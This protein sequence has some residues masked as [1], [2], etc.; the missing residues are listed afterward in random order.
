MTVY[1]DIENPRNLLSDLFDLGQDG[2][3]AVDF[4]ADSAG[5]ESSGFPAA[6]F[7]GEYTAEGRN[8]S[9]AG[10][11][12]GLKGAYACTAEPPCAVDADSAGLMSSPQAWTFTPDVVEGATIDVPDGDHLYFGWWLSEPEDPEG[13]Y[14]FRAFSGGSDSFEPGVKFTRDDAGLLEGKAE[15]RGL[16][17]GRYVTMDFSGGEITGADTGAFTATAELTAKFGGDDIAVNEHFSISGTV[18]DFRDVEDDD[19]LDD[20]S[21]ELNRIDLASGSASFE[22][23]ATEAQLGDSTGTGSWEGAFFGNGR[24]DGKPGSVAGTFEARLTAA[25]I[26][27]GFGA[28]NIAP[29]E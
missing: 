14:A 1:S 23:G 4:S 5:I 12:Y 10:T 9:F 17:A 18:T 26:S 24:S 11:F 27:G 19:P 22:G 21:V 6:G 15:Y 8:L 13:D 28:G 16:A 7:M 2:A 20:W 3:V 25:R 29:D